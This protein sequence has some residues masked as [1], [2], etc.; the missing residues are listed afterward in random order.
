MS[1]IRQSLF[2]FFVRKMCQ[3][4]KNE[5]LKE[6]MCQLEKNVLIT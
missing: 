3:E 1:K 2:L 6:K 4:E 5:V